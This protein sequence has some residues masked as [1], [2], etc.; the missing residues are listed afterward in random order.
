MHHLPPI[1]G[2][3]PPMPLMVVSYITYNCVVI[4]DI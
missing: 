3:V 1:G 4:V 2:G